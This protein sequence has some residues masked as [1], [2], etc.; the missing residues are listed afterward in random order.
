MLERYTR[1]EMGV[2]WS[3][4]NKFKKWLDVEIAVLE[5][6]EELG[7]IP[8]GVSAVIKQFA[9]FTVE[10][11]EAIEKVIDQDMVAFLRVVS[12]SLPPE[13]RRYPHEGL[14]SYDTEDTALAVQM[15]ESDQ[16]IKAVIRELIEVLKTIAKNYR[17][18]LEIGRTHG[19]HA[20][21]ITFG[22]LSSLIIG[23]FSKLS[24]LTS[25]PSTKPKPNPQNKL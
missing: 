23:S 20:E 21:P 16:L 25:L 8:K 12:N 19:I 17:D 4:E 7:L 10:E 3:K 2:I 24:C 14:T 9:K 6:K 13:V 11:I 5:A 18:A 15:K 22:F 1:P